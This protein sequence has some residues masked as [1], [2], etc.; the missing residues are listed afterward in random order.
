MSHAFP[1]AAVDTRHLGSLFEPR[2]I[3][4]IGASAQPERIGGRPV[5]FLREHGYEGAIYPINP[6]SPQVQ[7][8]PAYASIAETPEPP[9]LVV[10]SLPAEHV[11]EQLA[12]CAQRGVK[13][14]IVF[15]SG[16][17]EAGAQGEA[18]QA[19][20]A[21]LADETGLRVLGPN[22][23]GVMS[24]A[25]K[26]LCTFGAAPQFGLPQ[27]GG[28]SIV[29]QSGAFGTYTFMA[30]KMRDLPIS[31]WVSTGNEADIDFAD[32]VAWLA[33]DPETKVIM[34]YMEGCRNGRKLMRAFDLAR[35]AGKPVVVIKV[36]RTETGAAASK[37][38]TAALSGSDEVFDAVF[39]QCGVCRAATVD[40][41]FDVGYA[42]LR[43]LRPASAR[44]GVITASGGAG[45]LMADAAE[46]ASLDVAPLPAASQAELVNI[47][48]F[49]GPRN[50][51]DIT[52]QAA[53]DP[54]LF[55]K[56]IEVMIRDGD[57]GAIACFSGLSG[58]GPAAS[59]NF[60]GRWRRLRE[61]YPAMP[62]YVAMMSRPEVR[63]EF[64][65]LNIPVFDEPT[66]MVRAIAALR[67]LARPF[68]ARPERK[69]PSAPI[70]RGAPAPDVLKAA[71][72]PMGA[73]SAEGCVAAFAAVRLDPV[74]GPIVTLWLGGA[75]A[76]TLGDVS[77]RAA[78][79]DRDEALE[80]IGELRAARLL[81]AGEGRPPSDKAALADA[82]AA[83]SDF[84]AAQAG[85]FR[86][87]EI[88]P[89]LVR[90]AG[91]GVVGVG[92]S[93]DWS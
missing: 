92:A 60:L 84:A 47:V 5:F 70:E 6:R 35:Q 58:L 93:I 56:F 28:V 67:R 89:L 2:S 4:I 71:G 45:V 81:D 72:L 51:V 10:V 50:P 39:R 76:K 85:A 38:H 13:A 79:F 53:N 49:C 74:F 32:C 52:G 78:P 27:S 7:G 36:G 75:L 23:L 43:G 24:T 12:L 33:D 37:A 77:C 68:R 14:A 86:S 80:M 63:R 15:S 54:T 48:P 64:E 29:S 66:R 42:C 65:A 46:A 82:L 11:I 88:D 55:G 91:E 30:G 25:S 83:L 1:D 34:G 22:C 90:A 73:A 40:E 59:G 19:R 17:A 87:I 41:F 20:M 57:Y 44:L 18:D 62:F 3:G 16:F 8:L 69:P 21:A 31:R 26:V 61:Q 9:E